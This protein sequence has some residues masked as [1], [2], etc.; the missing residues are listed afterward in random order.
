MSKIGTLK[1]LPTPSELRASVQ[2][3][4][5]LE[6]LPELVAHEVT[7]ALLP[8]HSLRN[9]VQQV[10][11]AYDQVT[12]AQRKTLD[13]LAT[14]MSNRA[15]EAMEV[16]TAA[17]DGVITDLS[18]QVNGLQSSMKA[19]QAS[20]AKLSALPS[21]LSKTAEYSARLMKEEAKELMNAAH[22][23]R[24]TVMRDLSFMLASAALAA[25]L[26]VV[27]QVALSRLLPPSETQQ[28]ANWAAA[29][30]ARASEQERK[31]MNEIA[32]R[33]AR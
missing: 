13:S 7:Q 4:A 27:G 3:L 9:Q 1:A 2:E 8:L 17:L 20:T 21:E 32:S 15:A 11:E 10:L 18:K 24:P 30:W 6:Q 28:S 16:K 22:L 23:A 33:P 19:V 14:E 31:L 5:S 25:L 12:K 29:V 26:V